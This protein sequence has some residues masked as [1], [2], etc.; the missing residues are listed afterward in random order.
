MMNAVGGPVR[1]G[2]KH[3]ARGNPLRQFEVAQGTQLARGE[4]SGK[5]EP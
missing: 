1:D 4:I 2:K 5:L 3:D